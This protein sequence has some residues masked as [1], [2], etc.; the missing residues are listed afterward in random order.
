[1]FMKSLGNLIQMEVI[2]SIGLS[3]PHFHLFAAFL[4]HPDSSVDCSEELNVLLQQ[5][6][7]VVTTEQLGNLL[8]EINPSGSGEINFDEFYQC[9]PPPRL[10]LLLLIWDDRV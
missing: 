1:M 10:L 8:K 3:S 4:P 5:L 9:K 6:G 2:R 7:V